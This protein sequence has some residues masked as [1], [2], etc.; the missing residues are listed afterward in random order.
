MRGFGVDNTVMQSYY[1]NLECRL[2]CFIF[3]ILK[4]E[5][6]MFQFHKGK[7]ESLSSQICY[8]LRF[9]IGGINSLNSG[10]SLQ[11]PLFSSLRLEQQ[12]GQILPLFTTR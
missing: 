1:E 4:Q 8:F 6:I 7:R 3:L 11:R 9:N 10:K 5:M 2:N 12:N